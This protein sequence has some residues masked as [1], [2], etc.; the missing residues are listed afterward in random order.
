MTIIRYSRLH[1][2]WTHHE[3]SL[4]FGHGRVL[5]IAH[6]SSLSCF[7]Q[8]SGDRVGPLIGILTSRNAS[9]NICGD[10]KRFAAMQRELRIRGGISFVFTPEDIQT[11]SITGYVLLSN[12]TWIAC[13]FPYPDVI[14]NR[15]P[16][17]S[18]ENGESCK[19][20]LSLFAKADI[21]LFNPHFFS[22]W[23]VHQALYRNEKIRSFLLPTV[24]L[25]SPEHLIEMLQSYH[26]LYVKR[27]ASSKGKHLFVM[28]LMKDKITITSPTGA[29]QYLEHHDFRGLFEESK[30]YLAQ[31]ALQHDSHNNHKYDLRILVHYLSGSFSITGIGIRVAPVGGVVTHVHYG[32][33]QIHVNELARPIQYDTLT[34][35][36][37]QC[38]NSLCTYFGKVREFSMDIGVDTNGN[39]FIYECNAKP[40]T[41]DEREIEVQAIQNIVTICE[42][43]AGFY[44]DS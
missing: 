6:S 7:V 36:A 17:R 12:G 38:G 23:D 11:S 16:Y 24:L 44:P 43:E 13:D 28:Q 30:L 14:Y 4:K 21:P 8:Q 10:W 15:I 27:C 40:M 32:G 25:D 42:Q 34:E 35:L 1:K 5:A 39:Y 19:H 18:H 3:K 37:R 26:Q 41:F 33:E 22:K 20:A 9:G 2:T 29:T 31:P